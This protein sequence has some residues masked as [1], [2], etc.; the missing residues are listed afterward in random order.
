VADEIA[1]VFQTDAMRAEDGH[2]RPA[3]RALKRDWRIV[4]K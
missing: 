2:E 1:D 4:N 3:A